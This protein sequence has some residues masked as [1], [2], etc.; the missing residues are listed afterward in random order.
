MKVSRC[1][2]RHRLAERRPT[3]SRR[4]RRDD[5]AV[6]SFSACLFRHTGGTWLYRF[7]PVPSQQPHVS[8]GSCASAA[9]RR[10]T[11][12]A[13]EPSTSSCC[14]RSTSLTAPVASSPSPSLL[15]QC[16]HSAVISG[17][18]QLAQLRERMPSPNV[19]AEVF[20]FR[21][22]VLSA[23]YVHSHDAYSFVRRGGIAARN[24]REWSEPRGQSSDAR[25]AGGCKKHVHL[26]ANARNERLLFTAR[27][28]A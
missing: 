23:K 8:S 9:S 13:T 24:A 10:L 7:V 11:Y 14:R 2:I 27:L 17:A 20:S 1:Q 12:A 6:R 21:R 25:L 22:G 3:P 26:R 15:C 19:T 16:S 28:T 4:F 18:A 5:S